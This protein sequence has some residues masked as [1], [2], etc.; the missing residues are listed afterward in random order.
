MMGNPS[1]AATLHSHVPVAP[2]GAYAGF[3]LRVIA[4]FL[5]LLPVGLVAF[6]LTLGLASLRETQFE[7][8]Y[9]V[10]AAVLF[11]AYTAWFESSRM[12][13]TPG[14]LLLGLVVTDEFGGR[15][16]FGRA[17]GRAVAK[18][19]PSSAL[20]GLGFYMILASERRQALHDRMAGTLVTRRR[21]AV[22]EAP[23]IA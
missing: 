20:Y 8:L 7:P 6:V 5:D 15:L 10:L 18:L 11:L 4:G 22:A 1:I 2:A 19:L 17:L 12:R 21:R 9:Q 16:S 3:W 13:A 23:G 14:K